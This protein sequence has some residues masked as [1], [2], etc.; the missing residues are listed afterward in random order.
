ML[1]LLSH[2]V[3]VTYRRYLLQRREA[4]PVDYH[5]ADVHDTVE[6]PRRSPDLK[7]A[8]ARRRFGV[9]GEHVAD[10]EPHGA[11]EV[12]AEGSDGVDC[13]AYGGG[14]AGEKLRR[15]FE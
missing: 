14:V 5:G 9:R 1:Y 10:E 4:G 13:D 11:D 8:E 6:P 12:V 3:A 7:G 15:D 2:E